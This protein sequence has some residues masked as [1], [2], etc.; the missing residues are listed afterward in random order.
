MVASTNSTVPLADFHQMSA[1]NVGSRATSQ[2]ELAITFGE[3]VKAEHQTAHVRSAGQTTI[4]EQFRATGRQIRLNRSK[5]T[6]LDKKLVALCKNVE[7]LNFINPINIASERKKFLAKKGAV[8]PEFN[9]KQ[10]NINPYQFNDDG[11]SNNVTLN[12]SNTGNQPA[13]DGMELRLTTLNLRN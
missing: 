12:V 11:M 13:S 6:H 1:T 3:P 9:Y 5:L 4:G 10:L 7:T 8:T 2:T